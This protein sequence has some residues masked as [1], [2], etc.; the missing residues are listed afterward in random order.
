M[1]QIQASKITAFAAHGP[2]D[3][4]SVTKIVGFVILVPGDDGSGGE[5]PRQAHGYAQ[6]IRRG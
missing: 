5:Q 3:E 6:T 1:T 2:S 4:I